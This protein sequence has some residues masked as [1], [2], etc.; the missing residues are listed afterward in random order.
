VN[1]TARGLVGYESSRTM[2]LEGR[3][4]VLEEG[5]DHHAMVVDC[6][7]MCNT[8]KTPCV[9]STM[10]TESINGLEDVLYCRA[11]MTAE[12]LDEDKGMS[13][14]APEVHHVYPLKEVRLGG[15]T[16]AST[17]SQR[18]ESSRT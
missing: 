10:V 14:W 7:I 1:R 18:V 2:S 16:S 17:S 12:S 5:G 4:R 13:S 8:V 6:C 9:S 15:S 3:Q 11:S